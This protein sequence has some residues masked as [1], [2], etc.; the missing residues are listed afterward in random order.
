[1]KDI[2]ELSEFVGI[3]IFEAIFLSNFCGGYNFVEDIEIRLSLEI[4][5]IVI[6]ISLT[7]TIIESTL[8][9]SK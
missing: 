7:N 2:G 6:L 5:V 8:I 4:L 1:L 9:G 3:V